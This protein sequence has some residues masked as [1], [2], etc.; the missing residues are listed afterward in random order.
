MPLTREE[1]S[2]NARR[3]AL[4]R[5][6]R[7]SPAQNAARGQAG[8]LKK[9]EKEVDPDGVLPEKERQRRAECRRRVHMIEL[10]QMAVEA[11]AVKATPGDGE[12]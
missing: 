9:F 11:R 6:S 8:L 2:Q 1:R 4:I 3:A 5:W 10:S 12:A 7:E